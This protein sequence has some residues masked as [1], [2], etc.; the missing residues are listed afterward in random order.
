M[1]TRKIS[2]DKR[3]PVGYVVWAYSFF[4]M[5]YYLCRWY[6]YP[7][8]KTMDVFKFKR[9]RVYSWLN[10]KGIMRTPEGCVMKLSDIRR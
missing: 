6:L 2:M 7:L 5:E 10:L 8:A 3:I 9:A 4:S 1:I